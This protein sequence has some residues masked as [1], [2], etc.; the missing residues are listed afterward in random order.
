M[1]EP[2][3]LNPQPKARFIGSADACRIHRKMMMDGNFQHA[4]DMALLQYQGWL[5]NKTTDANSAAQNH[6]KIAGALEFINV[7]KHLGEVPVAVPQKIDTDN[8]QHEQLVV[9]P[10]KK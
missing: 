8:L 9:L 4:I 10:N 6:F 5:A 7:F 2:L 3:N 1:S